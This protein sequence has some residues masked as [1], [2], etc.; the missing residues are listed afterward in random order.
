[1]KIA[2]LIGS[3]HWQLDCMKPPSAPATTYRAQRGFGGSNLPKANEHSRDRNRRS[4]TWYARNR[5]G[6]L[7]HRHLSPILA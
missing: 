6:G 7:Y 3:L 2:A 5:R 4:A 1:M